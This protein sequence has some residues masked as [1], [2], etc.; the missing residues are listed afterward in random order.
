M[1]IKEQLVYMTTKIEVATSTGTGSGTGF[2]YKFCETDNGMHFPAIIT[3]KHVVE[4]AKEI[5]FCLH[6]SDT[7]GQPI[8]GRFEKVGFKIGQ[9]PIIYHPNPK[10]DLCAVPLGP[11]QSAM[12]I[13]GLKTFTI[14]Q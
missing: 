11:I 10:I 2:F 12:E 6:I 4:N 3:N 9:I 1:N 13:N 7:N 5:S 14:S 8:E